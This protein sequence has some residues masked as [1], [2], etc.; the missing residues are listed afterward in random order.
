MY[1]A[2]SEGLTQERITVCSGPEAAA[3]RSVC[4]WWCG[5]PARFLPGRALGVSG[6]VAASGS[7][8][9]WVQHGLKQNHPANWLP[10]LS[11]MCSG[12]SVQAVGLP[13]MLAHVERP[14][15]WPL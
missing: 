7:A 5:I 4:R 10:E 11:L 12:P 8:V 1:G 14:W 3:S 2:P 9:P 15:E 6:A 13:E